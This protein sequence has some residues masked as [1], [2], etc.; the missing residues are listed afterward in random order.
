MTEQSTLIASCA[1]IPGIELQDVEVGS[2]FIGGV[3]IHGEQVIIFD[4]NDEFLRAIVNNSKPVNGIMPPSTDLDMTGRGPSWVSFN[5]GLIGNG[6]GIKRLIEDDRIKIIDIDISHKDTMMSFRNRSFVSKQNLMLAICGLLRSLFPLGKEIPEAFR[7]PK[8][9]VVKHQTE[10]RSEDGRPP[11]AS[12]LYRWE[13]SSDLR[14]GRHQEHAFY[15]TGWA[16]GPDFLQQVINN[17]ETIRS[18]RYP[19][20]PEQLRV[21]TITRTLTGSPDNRPVSEQIASSLDGRWTE[22]VRRGLEFGVRQWER[23]QNYLETEYVPHRLPHTHD[24]AYTVTSI[25]QEI[26][27]DSTITRYTVTPNRP[28][29]SLRPP[30]PQ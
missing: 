6:D 3:L 26:T 18:M 15:D 12:S 13:S 29:F 20:P 1:R 27:R 25:E 2:L 30:E 24:E 8:S 7:H 16:S 4:Q 11:R 22:N 14:L 19:T 5:T 23:Q 10:L 21:E 9:P 17:A 28:G